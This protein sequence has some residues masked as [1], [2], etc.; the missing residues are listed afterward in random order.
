MYSQH[1]LIANPG[2]LDSLSK[3]KLTRII[4]GCQAP[5]LCP[6]L[7]HTTGLYLTFTPQGT[8]YM[9]RSQL[10]LYYCFHKIKTYPLWSSP[11]GGMGWG[12]NC[13]IYF[14]V[15]VPRCLMAVSFPVLLQPIWTRKYSGSSGRLQSL[16][17]NSHQMDWENHC[18]TGDDEARP[19]RG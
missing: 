9:H 12:R 4:M 3:K 18:P 8:G 11:T 15:F 17:W 13:P 1:C 16:P 7:A 2:D 6:G 19:G 5:R 14:I 10:A